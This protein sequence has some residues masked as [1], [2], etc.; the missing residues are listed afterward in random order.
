MA[1]SNIIQ[2]PLYPNMP[3]G[4]EIIFVIENNDAVQNQKQVKFGVN[5]HISNDTMPSVSVTTHLVGTFKTTPNN[6]TKKYL[7]KLSNPG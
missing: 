3:V 7:L 5:V 2:K 4:Q 1:A 6:V